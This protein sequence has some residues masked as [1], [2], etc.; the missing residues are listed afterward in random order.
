MAKLLLQQI[1]K[2]FGATQAL[3]D[4]SLTVDDGEFLVLLGPSGAGKTTTLKIIA[5]VEQPT[6]GLIYFDDR[7]MNAVEPQKRNVAM[8]FESYALYPHY[9]VADNLASPLRA[10]GVKLSKD[11]VKRRVQEMAELLNIHTLLD[12]LPGQLS[13]GQKQRVSLGRAMIREPDILLLDEPISHLD[14]KLR[15]RMR[16]EFKA[17]ESDIQTTTVYVTHDYIE[18]LSLADRIAVINEGV[19]HQVGSPR[20]VFNNPA[21]IFVSKLL[22]EPQI[23]LFECQFALYDGGIEL[24][25]ADSE[26][27]IMTNLPR[28]RQ[29]LAQLNSA[30]VTL[31]IRPLHLQ[32]VDPTSSTDSTADAIQAEMVQ[33]DATVYVYERLGTKGVLTAAVGTYLVNVITP[34]EMD[35]RIDEQV[36]L[37]FNLRDVL[38]FDPQT[39][40]NLLRES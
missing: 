39:Q 37:Q 27:Q 31:G 6:S 23:N 14:A 4:L 21:D 17:L 40:K 9:K 26:L 33:L 15:H 5:G 16:T 22:G 8:A 7:L 35:F 25:T 3:N 11:E 34:I 30:F 10:P 29:R 36:R 24:C 28:I 12:R 32:V 20:E 19:L 2:K 13:N 38:Y 18:A 1:T